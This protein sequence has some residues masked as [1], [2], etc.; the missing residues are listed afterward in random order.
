MEVVGRGD[1][2]GGYRGWKSR[3]EGM[4]VESREEERGGSCCLPRPVLS[5]SRSR[6]PLSR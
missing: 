1:G 6:F 4:E 5:S 2:S 3:A